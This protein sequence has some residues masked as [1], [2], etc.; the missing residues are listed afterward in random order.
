VAVTRV[1]ATAGGVPFTGS[2]R[3]QPGASRP[4]TFS[5]ALGAVEA[6]ALEH[7]L[8]PTLLRQQGFL[9][10]TLG[11]GSSPPAPDWLR[12]RKADGVIA[13]DSVTAG[14]WT[15][16]GLKA[17]LLWDGTQV[18]L[19]NAAGTIAP[20]SFAGALT[21]DLQAPVPKY[22]FDGEL[23]GVPYNGGRVDLMGTLDAEG[24]GS[25]WIDSAR[26]SGSLRGRTIDFAPEAEFRSIA[27]CFQIQSA[28]AGP[29]WHL[30]DVEANQ[31]GETLVGAGGSQ[32]DG[33][34]LLELT[35]GE[36]QLHYTSALF[37]QGAAAVKQ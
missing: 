18:R 19:A 13:V 10:R 11:L 16:R 15:L 24:Q 20:S 32:P 31:A 6:A 4:H 37:A 27:A 2:Y 23:T 26:A 9:A 36:R 34:L 25:Q 21:V 17:R 14:A 8:E 3:W 33:Q 5:I 35:Q 7:L 22:H 30:Y 29:R 28:G 12:Q 1:K